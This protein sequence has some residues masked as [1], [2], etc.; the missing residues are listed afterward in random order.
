M[1]CGFVNMIDFCTGG[2][3]RVRLAQKKIAIT[4][5]DRQQIIEVMGYPTRQ[6]SHGLHF[7]CL[8]KLLFEFLPLTDILLNG[9]EVAQLAPLVP[10]W[11]YGHLL[12][13][14]I[15]ILAA[16]DDFTLPYEPL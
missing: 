9:N 13:E 7:L 12:R 16:I 14:Q 3:S 15:A 6:A 11:S 8:H 10:H 5:D 2:M 4:Q 1:P